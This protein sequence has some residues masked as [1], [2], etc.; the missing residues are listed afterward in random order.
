M[1]MGMRFD[2]GLRRLATIGIFVASSTLG[3]PATSSADPV[4]LTY[5]VTIDTRCVLGACS[6][7]DASFNL[8]VTFDSQAID[9][10]ASRAMPS[11]SA[12][13]LRSLQSRCRAPA[14]IRRPHRTSAVR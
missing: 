8:S 12:A 13:S 4:T 7:F 9:Q 14:S 1:R 10:G 5:V 3:T 2:K 11:P 6:A